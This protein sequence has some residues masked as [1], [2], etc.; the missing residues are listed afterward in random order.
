MS[1]IPFPTRL[2]GESIGEDQ[3]ERIAA[4]IYGCTLQVASVLV[5]ALWQYAVRERLVRPDAADEELQAFT[6]RLKPGLAGYVV[7]IRLGLFLPIVAVVGY[8][9]IALYLL[10]PFALI[11]RHLPL[12]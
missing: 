6:Q 12:P 9:G 7:L 2:V 8:L 10:A 5:F 3:P 4:T 1:F 11:R